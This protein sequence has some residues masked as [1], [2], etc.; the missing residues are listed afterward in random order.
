MVVFSTCCV[1][2]GSTHDNLNCCPFHLS[3]TVVAHTDKGYRSELDY[4][5][6]D[7]YIVHSGA[8][9][10]SKRHFDFY[11]KEREKR[12]S[13]IIIEEHGIH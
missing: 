12:C 4:I 11:F 3:I 7:I 10:L 2:R 6:R 5:D 1:G 8:A 9:L 13:I